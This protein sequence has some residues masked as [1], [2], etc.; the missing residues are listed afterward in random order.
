MNKY[1][2]IDT[3]TGGLSSE[4]N[5][6]LQVAAQIYYD[7]KLISEFNEKMKPEE[8]Q[9]LDPIALEV[10][11]NTVEDIKR[12]PEHKEVFKRFTQWMDNHIDKY[13]REDKYYQVGYNI[14][15]FDAPFLR[16]WF[17]LND[18][19]YYGSY[20]YNP[21]VDVMLVAMFAC[22]GQRQNIHNFKL[23]TVCKSLG[24]KV[25]DAKLHDAMYDTE[26]TAELFFLLK[27]EFNI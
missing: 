10:N 23:V 1:L 14:H 16:A 4:K 5:P 26:I 3:E 7:D 15:S 25:E 6:I 17:H 2:V 24:I 21:P 9:T 18:H 27:K 8:W 13:N 11:G 20:F 12:F 22:I 19:K